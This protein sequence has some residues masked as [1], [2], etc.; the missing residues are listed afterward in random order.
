LPALQNLRPRVNANAFYLP[1]SLSVKVREYVD[2]FRMYLWAFL[3][4]PTLPEAAASTQSLT[5]PTHFPGSRSPTR[6]STRGPSAGAGRS[7]LVGSAP[8]PAP[9]E[10]DSSS[11]PNIESEESQ[12]RRQLKLNL[13]A[14]RL[15]RSPSSATPKGLATINGPTTTSVLAIHGDNSSPGDARTISQNTD[16]KS[17]EGASSTII[18]AFEGTEP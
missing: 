1:L 14:T 10:A 8:V 6:V 9:P 2:V 12:A 3:A 18:T 4:A 16:T 15:A 17:S 13:S 5:W 7:E 11:N